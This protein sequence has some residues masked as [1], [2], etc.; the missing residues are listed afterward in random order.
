M[1]VIEDFKKRQQSKRLATCVHFNGIMND[2]CKVGVTYAS[3]RDGSVRPYR[4]PCIGRE[5]DPCATTCAKRQLPTLAE[6]EA[7]EARFRKSMA[8]T[9]TARAEIVEN[10]GPWKRGEPGEEG[11]TPCPVCKSGTLHFTRSG[12]NGHIHAAC[13]T[14]G[15]VRW[16]E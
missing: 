2:A 13:S 4:F 16:M 1:S 14:R 5:G 7:E 15:C 12:F 3:V 10:I 6:V 11:Q 8:D 9:M